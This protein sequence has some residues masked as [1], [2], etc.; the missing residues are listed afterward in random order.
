MSDEVISLASRRLSHEALADAFLDLETDVIELQCA[1]ELTLVALAAEEDKTAAK[2]VLRI[3]LE[4][5]AARA[6]DLKRK[7]YEAHT[8][9]G[10]GAS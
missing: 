5:F 4:H 7:W 10:G 8:R 3:A 1:A 9:G 2:G 6:E